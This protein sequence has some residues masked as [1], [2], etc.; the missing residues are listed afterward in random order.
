[1]VTGDPP[2]HERR[3]KL[4]MGQMSQRYQIIFVVIFGA[5][6]TATPHA[7][8][9]IVPRVIGSILVISVSQILWAETD[10]RFESA[11]I[12]AAA[13]KWICLQTSFRSRHA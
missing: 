11:K 4:E 8:M 13:F 10:K 7:D 9:S 6:L 1:M 5:L 12:N 3:L 2:S